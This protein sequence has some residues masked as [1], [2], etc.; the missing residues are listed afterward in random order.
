MAFIN[1]VPLQGSR[2]GSVVERLR[3]DIQDPDNEDQH[4]VL[5]EAMA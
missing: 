3:G 5:M 1:F 2:I 4:P